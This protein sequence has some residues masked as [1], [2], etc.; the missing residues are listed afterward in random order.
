MAISNQTANRA[1]ILVQSLPSEKKFSKNEVNLTFK[2]GS[3][4][5]H[6]CVTTFYYSIYFYMYK[7]SVVV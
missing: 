6:V 5:I 2:D 7:T 3:I 1:I 4:F